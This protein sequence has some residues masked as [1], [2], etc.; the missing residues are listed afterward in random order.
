MSW[1]FPVS[2]STIAVA[3]DLHAVDS[4]FVA[5][6]VLVA[7]TGNRAIQGTGSDHEVVVAG[8]VVAGNGSHTIYL[9]DDDTLDSGNSITVEAG[10]DIRNFVNYAVVLHGH[11][12]HITNSGLIYGAN[13]GIYLG[14]IDPTSVTTIVNSGTI[15]SDVVGITRAASTETVAFTNRGT[16]SAPVAYGPYGGDSIA[17]DLI[18]NTGRISGSSTSAAATTATAALPAISPASSS[19][20]S[21]TMWR[22]AASRTTGSKAASET[23]R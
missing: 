21:A 7:S 22:S 2:I 13:G 23:T 1:Q 3:V 4:V 10:G 17:R 8:S 16:L 20:A 6:G 14:G 15:T 5:K 9:G 18:T 19:R 11:G 12:N